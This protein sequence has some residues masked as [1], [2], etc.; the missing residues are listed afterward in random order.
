MVVLL[1]PAH[2]W[3]NQPQGMGVYGSDHVTRGASRQAGLP[4][5]Q[6][7]AKAKSTGHPCM[8]FCKPGSLVCWQHGGAAP[9]VQRKADERMTLRQLMFEQPPRP[10]IEVILDNVHTADAITREMKL[11]LAEGEAVTPQDL[12]R[13]LDLTRLS[14]H[15]AK[16]ALDSGVEIALVNQARTSVG[17]LG[18]ILSEVLLAVLH[19]LPLSPAWQEYFLAVAD[20]QLLV[21]AQRSG[22][23]VLDLPDVPA[24][25]P[26]PPTEPVLLPG[27]P[28]P[29]GLPRSETLQSPDIWPPDLDR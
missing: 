7:T 10:L 6:C 23:R 8:N 26:A 25:A 4:S 29:E 2:S 12:D 22:T 21:I 9:Q 13:L 24:D 28:N 11:R 20:H 1:P 3:F 14:Q 18:T 27:R 19:S 15:L 17:E 16:T 5:V